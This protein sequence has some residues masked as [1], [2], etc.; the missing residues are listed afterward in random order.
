M[1]IFAGFQGVIRIARLVREPVRFV[2]RQAAKPSGAARYRLRAS[3]VSIYIRHGTADVNTL[4]QIFR[5]GHYRLPGVPATLLDSV[6]RPLNVVDFGANIGLFGAQLLE[7]FPDA[8]IV[9]FE[10]DP[11]NVETLRRMI[12][13]NRRDENW[14]LVAAC[15]APEDGTLP[16]TVGGF[17]NSRV[18]ALSGDRTA[19]IRAVEVFPYLRDVDLLKIDIEGSEWPIVTDPRFREVSARVVALEYHPHLCPA[20]DPRALA[21][22]ILEQAGY[23]TEDGE[24]EALPGHGMVW[25]WRAE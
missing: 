23:E 15:A 20:E 16:F 4:D 10:P 14:E 3:G 9:A 12:A 2:L 6:A 8:R 13:A 21:I 11:G 22:S 19:R 1:R 5:R 7:R 24:L 25:A 17:A 18:E